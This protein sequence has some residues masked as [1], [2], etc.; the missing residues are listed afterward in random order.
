VS[1]T[2]PKTGASLPALPIVAAFVFAGIVYCG[3]K[4]RNN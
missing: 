3:K 1:A 4:V 2:S